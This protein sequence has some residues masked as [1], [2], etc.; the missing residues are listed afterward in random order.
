MPHGILLLDKPLGLSSNAAVQRVRRV[1][2]REKA[3]HTGSLDPLATGML[4]ICLG[5]ATKVAGYLL[6]GDKEY[7]FTMRL[8]ERTATGDLE[9]EVVERCEPPADPAAALQAVIPAFLGPLR[10]VPPMY[11]A[12]KR[13]GQPLYQLARQ[14]IE[15]EREARHITIHDLQL[16][17]VEGTEA[18]LRVICSKGTYVRT[19]AEDLARAAGSCAHLSALRRTLVAPFPG[20][21][22][23][24]LA[25]LE[26]DPAA[27]QLLAPDAAVPQLPAA[28]IDAEAT[29][30]VRMGQAVAA[31]PEAGAAVGLVR[32][33]GPGRVFLGIGERLMAG[34][35]TTVLL[36]PVRL[37][38]DLGVI[39]A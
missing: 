39:T 33:Y 29:R 26:A 23:V 18:S 15:V 27:A 6:E 30:R 35:G 8:G 5:E 3:G 11:S 34:N 7:E 21:A 36:K 31:G 9:G 17:A 32:L 14:G 13:E 25:A 28:E 20:T 4:P 16:L 37:F 22:M 38:N 24:T 19:L 10:Q 12:L 2:A 1:F